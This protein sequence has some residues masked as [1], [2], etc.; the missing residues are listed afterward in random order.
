MDSLSDDQ[1]RLISRVA[2]A[3]PIV[4]ARVP[5]RADCLVQALAAQRWLRRKGIPTTL[6][7]GVHKEIPAEFEAHAWLMQGGTI[8]T[9]GDIKRFT[10]LSD[11]GGQNA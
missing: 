1:L 11:S 8:I 5:W 3:V 4:A 10:P 9:G 2:F 7:V 6:H